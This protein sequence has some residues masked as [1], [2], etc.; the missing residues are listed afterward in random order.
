MAKRKLGRDLSALLS[1]TPS[2]SETD[3]VSQVPV[4]AITPNPYQP[5]RPFDKEAMQE[6]VV[7]IRQHGV[8]QPI[9]V[10]PSESGYELIAGERRW[11]AA[12][13]AN[14]TTI[15]AVVRHLWRG[16]RTPS[17]AEIDENPR[18][19]AARLRAVER[20]EEAA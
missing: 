12:T 19:E 1:G 7:S 10:R 5:R 4:N 6:L 15:P 16:T 18:A 17:Q 11:R 14:L 20:L 2:A 8:L 13:T 3:N 9:V